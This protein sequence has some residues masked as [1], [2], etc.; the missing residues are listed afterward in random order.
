MML[1]QNFRSMFREYDVR[2]RLSAEELNE[3]SVARIAAAFAVF[4]RRRNVSRIVVGYDSR[5]CSP[6]FRDIA[7][8]A[9]LDLGLEVFDL[10][11]SLSPV[12]YFAQH[13][14]DSPGAMMI[15]ASHNPDGWSG[16]KLASEKSVTLTKDD[17]QELLAIVES[18]ETVETRPGSVHVVNVRDAYIENIVSRVKLNPE[19]LPRV[20][21]DA[22]NGGAGVFAYEVLHRLGCLTFQLNCDPDT[23]F[24][25]YFPNPSDV[26][27]RELLKR[28]LLHP[29]VHADIAI[30]FDGD[31]DRI[32]VL[33]ENGENI[34]ADKLLLLLIKPLLER[35]PGASVVFD[36]KC[37]QAIA[38]FLN[39]HGGVPV[40][41]NTGHSYIKRKM[42]E[43]DADLGGERSGHL[44]LGGDLYWGFDDAIFAAAKLLEAI[45]WEAKP[46]SQLVAQFPA[47]HVSSEIAAPCADTLKYDVVERVK[48]ELLRRFPD[49]EYSTINGLK[50]YFPE[51]WGLVRASS[52]MPELGLVFEAK[53]PERLREYYDA[54]RS[55]LDGFPEVERL[56]HNDYFANQTRMR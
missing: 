29:Y 41:W 8:R 30:S 25:R 2:G 13:Y 45:S 46:I 3:A 38:D 9:F 27:A 55:V 53:T 24:P 48:S 22:A 33:D 16:F 28:T 42:R 32:G 7:V 4:L 12:C 20:V 44:Y 47:Y 10:G 35:K 11:L 15:T 39:A 1:T 40:M 5:E 18:G 6:G 56:W 49:C 17:I 14:L 36:V 31:G 37:T 34:W 50:L 54:F 43:V 52:N 19:N 21:V 23:S 51:G 26:R